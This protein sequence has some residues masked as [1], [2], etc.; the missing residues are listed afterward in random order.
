MSMRP[1]G[2]EIQ[3]LGEFG[4]TRSCI[5]AVERLLY[6]SHEIEEVRL[7]SCDRRHAFLF[8][9]VGGEFIVVRAGFTSDSGEGSRGLRRALNLIHSVALDIEEYN[10]DRKLFDRL[11]GGRLSW[12]EF[13]RIIQL[14]PVRP[15]QLYDYGLSYAQSSQMSGN[16][17]NDVDPTFA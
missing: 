12:T 13:E 7:M 1:E 9:L 2:G 6:R 10:L 11:N 16:L 5:Q 15:P 3:Y 14:R 4:V 8:T 17:W